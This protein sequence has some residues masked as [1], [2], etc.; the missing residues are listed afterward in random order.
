MSARSVCLAAALAILVISPARAGDPAQGEKLF[1]V[2]CGPCHA[3]EPGKT[4]V[5]PS[6]FGVIGRPA[7]GIDGFPYSPAMAKAGLTW[8]GP[9]LDRFLFD[10]RAVVP[11]T[12]MTFPGL[13]DDGERADVIAYLA[14]LK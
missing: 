4:E 12:K 2:K 6:L 3:V 8:D 7:G 1:K 9:T 14:V 11:T 10:S 5:G 13:K